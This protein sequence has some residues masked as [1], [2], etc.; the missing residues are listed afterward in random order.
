MYD[1]ILVVNALIVGF[2]ETGVMHT[3]IIELHRLLNVVVKFVFASI[4]KH[5]DNDINNSPHP[6]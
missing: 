2:N 5:C 4:G 6:G 1:D 3:T